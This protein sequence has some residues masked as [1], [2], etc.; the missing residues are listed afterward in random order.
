VAPP[1]S[2]LEALK[3]GG[4]LIF[5]WHPAEHIGIALLARRGPEG[6]SVETVSGAW[7]IPCVGASDPSATVHAP[8]VSSAWSVRSLWPTARRS[9]DETAVAVYR[10]LWFSSREIPASTVKES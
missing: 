6:L 4:R 9:P 2:W 1:L 3:P 10:D 5:P 8:D 7:F